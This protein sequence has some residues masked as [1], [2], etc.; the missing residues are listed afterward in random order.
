MGSLDTLRQ[1]VRDLRSQRLR[2]FLTTFGIVWGTIAVSLLLAFG[3]GLHHQL[4]KNAAGLGNAIVI[5]WPSYTS[6]PFEGMGRGRGVWL[7]ESDMLLLKQHSREIGA[8]SSEYVDNLILQHGPRRLSVDVSGVHPSYGEMRNVIPKAGGRFINP[9]DQRLKRR[10]AFLG[11]ELAET[12]FGGSD[13]VGQSIRIHSSPFTIIGVLQPK[14]QQSSYSGRDKDQVFIPATTMQVITGQKYLENF[15]FTARDISR[16]QQANDEVLAILAKKHRFDP[17]DEEALSIWDTSEQ[18]QFFDTFM[19]AFKMFL[20]IVGMLT[21]VVGGIGVSN[22]MNVVVEERTREIGIK[23]ALGA[24]PG[25]ILRQFMLETLIITGVGGMI[26][27]GIAIAICSAVPAL[28]FSDFIGVPT[29]SLMVGGVT[30]LLLGAI[31][32]IAGFFPASSAAAMD[33]VVAMK[34]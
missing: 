33:P 31:G 17:K 11:D 24:K 19:L 15:I 28:G 30:A 3:E 32:L 8:L 16:T 1:L 9:I 29:V 14:I 25:S 21:L 27:L 10:V 12:L 4:I 7:D 34:S 22:I 2:T 18:A 26:G 13:P 5:V 6:I 23:M 20:G